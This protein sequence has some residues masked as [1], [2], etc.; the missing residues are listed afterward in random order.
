M[1]DFFSFSCAAVIVDTARIHPRHSLTLRKLFRAEPFI[2][3]LHGLKLSHS[4]NIKA[5]FFC[6][7]S[8]S[9][10][11]LNFGPFLLKRLM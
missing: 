7:A 3:W 1:C 9:F 2:S 6:A 4:L 8:C 11:A 10:L 5:D